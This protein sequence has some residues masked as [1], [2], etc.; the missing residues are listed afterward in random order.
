MKSFPLDLSY[1][2]QHQWWFWTYL[3]N[4]VLIFTYDGKSSVLVH[5]WSL[6]VEE[7]YYLAWPLFV[8]LIKNPKKLLL[9]CILG[10]ILVISTRVYIWSTVKYDPYAL[11][12][13]TRIDGLLVGS[14]LAIV[15]HVN[16]E[17]LRK[18]STI[19]IFILAA[20]NFTVYF[21]HQIFSF[22]VWPIAGY[23]SFSALFALLVY[24][25]IKRENKVINT[26]F[27]NPIL[28]FLGKYSYGF[29]V[30]H[31]PAYVIFYPYIETMVQNNL[32]LTGFNLQLVVS[33]IVT[34]MG[35][36]ISLISYHA[37]EK[38]WLNLKGRFT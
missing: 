1:Y 33:I 18:Y 21:L 9:C 2:K 28:R 20:L 8:V 17:I 35:F 22:P 36:A 37:Y 26:I 6:G 16:R 38:H 24:E 25:S 12:L 32:E 29:Y 15:Y 19:L 7:Q 10:L 11:F 14:M 27:T 23:A 31:W 30:F 13:F 4:W 3:Q 5:F 34:I